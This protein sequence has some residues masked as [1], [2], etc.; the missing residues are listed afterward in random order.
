M[1]VR[2]SSG[3]CRLFWLGLN[4]IIDYQ[5]PTP[6]QVDQIMLFQMND[7]VLRYRECYLVLRLTFNM[8]DLTWLTS[9][10][11][12]IQTIFMFTSQLFDSS[13]YVVI[14]TKSYMI[15]QIGFKI[16]LRNTLMYSL[17]G[18]DWLPFGKW[19]ISTKVYWSKIYVIRKIILIHDNGTTA[20]LC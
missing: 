20:I 6:H 9:D 18:Y 2:M 17:L 4:M 19:H 13:P 8:T 10:V 16:C 3:K 12:V 15:N 7:D 1:N 5:H 14:A 11:F